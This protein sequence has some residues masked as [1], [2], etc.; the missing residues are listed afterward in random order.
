M[1]PRTLRE[2]L[3][4]ILVILTGVALFMVLPIWYLVW[5]K[6]TKRWP[7]WLRVLTAPTAEAVAERQEE[8]GAMLN[9]LKGDRWPRIWVET[10]GT[11][12]RYGRLS[13]SSP[14]GLE[15]EDQE[16]RIDSMEPPGKVGHVDCFLD[17]LTS[18]GLSGTCYDGKGER[19]P[20]PGPQE[21]LCVWRVT[22]TRVSAERM[23][24][25]RQLDPK[26]SDPAC[27][28]QYGGQ[29]VEFA[30]LPPKIRKK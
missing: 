26:E 19:K 5:Q 8:L 7:A 25:E 9:A 20:K 4:S 10:D 12:S 30:W 3:R 22:L 28:D 6:G 15:P 11:W 27:L 29:L 21:G 24:G 16:L 2:R 17:E 1:L 14:N 23:Q 13:V 18:Q